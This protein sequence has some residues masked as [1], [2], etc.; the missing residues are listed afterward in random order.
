TCTPASV[1]IVGVADA[2]LTT[3]IETALPVILA[4]AKQ[5]EIALTTVGKISADV[6][7][8]AARL[9]GCA[10]EINAG[11]AAAFSGAVQATV[12]ASASVSVSFEASASVSGS[13]TSG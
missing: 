9:P 12:A 4:V 5:G 1:N 2:A 6:G 8:V 13:A 3:R 11:V 10:L 7:S